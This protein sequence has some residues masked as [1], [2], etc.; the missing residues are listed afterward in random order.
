MSEEI[1]DEIIIQIFGDRDD[2]KDALINRTSVNDFE[3]KLQDLCEKWEAIGNKKENFAD[4]S[5][6]YKSVNF[7]KNI[8]G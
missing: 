7:A 4:W 2:R 6:N 1:V 5:L 3:D 8:L